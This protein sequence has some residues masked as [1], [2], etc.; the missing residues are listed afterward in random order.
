MEKSY[1]LTSL[2]ICALY[3]LGILKRKVD[4][5]SDLLLFYEAPLLD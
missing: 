1:L 5:G 2:K 4:E 3:P